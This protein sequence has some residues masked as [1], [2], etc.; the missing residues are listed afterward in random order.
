MQFMIEVSPEVAEWLDITAGLE[1][2]PP[3]AI[4]RNIV[5]KAQVAAAM[6]QQAFEAARDADEI[7]Y[8]PQQ[9]P[10]VDD[11]DVLF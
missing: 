6:L 9:R 8:L 11:E 2:D 7:P 4:P 3:D 10:A 5:T 1:S